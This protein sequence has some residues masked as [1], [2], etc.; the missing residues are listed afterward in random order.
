[1]A[2]S[3]TVVASLR[4]AAASRAAFVCVRAVARVVLRSVARALL[5]AAVVLRAVERFVAC[6]LRAVEAL[7]DDAREVERADV[8]RAV[9]TAAEDLHVL[10]WDRGGSHALPVDALESVLAAARRSHELTVLDV[11][12]RLERAAVPVLAACDQVLLVVPAR[13][14][15]AA[16]ARRVADVLAPHVAD[17]R[18]VVRGP[19]PTGLGADAVVDAVGLPLAGDL[20]AEKDLD[21]AVD[22]GEGVLLRRRSPLRAWCEEWHEELTAARALAGTA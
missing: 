3:T 8:L 14:R 17:L 2:R 21:A 9:V 13:V 11:P 12:G 20:A 18:L 15:A 1:M 5:L 7:P 22:R 4:A 16:A 6:V 10:S 19:A